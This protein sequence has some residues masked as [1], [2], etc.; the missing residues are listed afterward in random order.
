MYG[1]TSAPA[2][3]QRIMEN[4]SCG[5]LGMAVFLDDI[6]IAGKDMEQHLK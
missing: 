2:I 4:I 3:W 1:V 6:R 5:I